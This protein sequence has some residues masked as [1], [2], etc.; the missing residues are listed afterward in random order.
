[1]QDV[2]MVGSRINVADPSYFSTI[3]IAVRRRQSRRPAAWRRAD[4][5]RRSLRSRCARGRRAV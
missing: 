5:S 4:A 2:F 3:I 1:M